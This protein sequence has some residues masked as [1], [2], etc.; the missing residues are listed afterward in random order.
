[1]VRMQYIPMGDISIWIRAMPKS[2]RAIMYREIP[3]ELIPYVKER[4]FIPWSKYPKKRGRPP[5]YDFLFISIVGMPRDIWDD[6]IYYLE[7]K[8]KRPVESWSTQTSEGLAYRFITPWRDREGKVLPNK[9]WFFKNLRYDI[10][11]FIQGK[12]LKIEEKENNPISIGK[13]EVKPKEKVKPEMSDEE[14]ERKVI[15]TINT[16]INS[17]KAIINSLQIRISGE[18]KELKELERAIENKEKEEER[19]KNKLESLERMGRFGSLF[20]KKKTKNELDRV[21]SDLYILRSKKKEIER[22]VRELEKE[23]KKEKE[24]AKKLNPS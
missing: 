6:L 16:I 18:R 17:K 19:L 10:L 15:D 4:I 22:K 5:K 11:N 24:E 3:E 7:D 20:E 21:K 8:L 2:S 13:E 12:H 14:L 9:M 23:L 1:M